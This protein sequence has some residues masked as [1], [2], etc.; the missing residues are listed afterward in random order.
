[1]ITDRC[2]PPHWD[3]REVEMGEPSRGSLAER[4]DRLVTISPLDE[5]PPLEETEELRQLVRDLR[6]PNRE[7]LHLRSAARG[8]G[9]ASDLSELRLLLHKLALVSNRMALAQTRGEL[10]EGER[11]KIRAMARALEIDDAQIRTLEECFARS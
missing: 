3:E 5:M 11:E 2:P 10:S 1:M 6:L 4:L 7:T 9:A 8:P